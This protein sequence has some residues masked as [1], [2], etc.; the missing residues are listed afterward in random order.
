MHQQVHICMGPNLW[1]WSCP[2]ALTCKKSAAGE[3]SPHHTDAAPMA[4]PPT[5]RLLPCS[6]VLILPTASH[7]LT[8][9]QPGYVAWDFGKFCSSQF[10]LNKFLTWAVN[11]CATASSQA[12][13]F[14]WLGFWSL[15]KQSWAFLINQEQ[16]GP[17]TCQPL[18]GGGCQAATQV[19]EESQTHRKS[20]ISWFWK[21]CCSPFPSPL[22]D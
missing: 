8:Y 22:Q 1:C 11:S 6:R 16:S 10:L 14:Q 18:W 13:A 21:R 3:R 9:G 20:G 17:A 5:S 15:L 12:Q 7:Q 4:S 2:Q 19:S